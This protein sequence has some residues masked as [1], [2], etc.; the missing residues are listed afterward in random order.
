MAHG[1]GCWAS[2]IFLI[3]FSD[4]LSAQ[5]RY[6]IVE[7][8]KHGAFVGNIAED[9]GLKVQ[10]LRTRKCRLLSDNNKQYLAM[11][12]DNGILFVNERIDRE[13]LCGQSSVCSIAFE[14]RVEYPL[15]MFGFEVEVLDLN[16]NSP[17]FPQSSFSIQV[18]ESIVPGARFPLERAQDP[19]V[20]TNTVST[21]Q[22]SSNE[23]FGL[24]M[25]T[26]RDGKKVAELFLEKPLDRERRSVFQLVLTAFDG[27]SPA[28]SGT[29]QIVINV[30]DINDN[31]PKFDRE[32][33]RVSM[34]EN[35][36]R[37]TFVTK[38]QAKDL[39]EGANAEIR[40]SFSE[41]AA[42]EEQELFTLDPKT[43]D[44]RVQGILDYEKSNVFELDVQA[45]DNGAFAM[46][47]RSKVVV[48]LID[49]NDNAPEIRLTSV[50]STVREDAVPGTVIAAIS[51]ADRDSG[52]NGEVQC[53]IP[54][55][56]PIK[57]QKSPTNQYK[58]VTNNMLDREKV[59]FYNVSITAWDSGSPPLSTNK[60][61]LVS[62]S[63]IND[64]APR[65][66][67][68]SYTAY[69]MENNAP[70]DSILSVT[71]LDP[72]LD[73]NSHVS[74][75][76]LEN[77]IQGMTSFPYVSIDSKSGNIYA[78]RSF[79]YERLK[80][81]QIQVQA[82]DSGSPSLSSSAAVNVIILDQNDNAPAVV[83]PVT[84]NGSAT[85]GPVPQSAPAGYLV[86]KV[87]A[88]DADSGQNA[89]LSYQ[90]RKATDPSLISVGLKTGEIKLIRSVSSHDATTQDLLIS[91]N[92]NGQPTLSATV[93][94]AF[95]IVANVTEKYFER[96][97]VL[98]N[99][100]NFSDL[101]LYLII[102]LGSTSFIFLLTIMVLIAIKCH[103]DSDNGD[104]CSF[105][106]CRMRDS[107]NSFMRRSAPKECLNYT[108][109]RDSVP[110]PGSYNYRFSV[111][112]DSS[113]TDFLFLK[114]Y[115]PTL[116]H[117]TLKMSDNN[118][119]KERG[120][121]DNGY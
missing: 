21:Y 76:I 92:D 68:S 73:Q 121:E 82:R 16:D 120:Q 119:A 50:S 114:T 86:T 15:E 29:A 53:Q 9:L 64:N 5:I 42:Q 93:T 38:V 58:L 18:A 65:F 79:D 117:S 99:A 115:A 95:S 56:L 97:N 45:V 113:K 8:L 44:I 100:N 102:T 48:T 39:D 107:G 11:N 70:G 85:V 72:D 54:Q 49:V 12:L 43:G 30:L 41:H 20:G 40:Y 4:L 19:D 104:D 78:L 61:I 71:A 35:A 27:G 57:L 3:I 116:P 26:R 77:P 83:S 94:I 28:L 106:C 25:Q 14:V 118:M 1:L 81:F 84:R 75:S 32:E 2:F 69:V 105:C 63:D 87:M 103:Q 109:V 22:I 51:V 98:E 33:Y 7:E 59:E 23:N 101:N 67:Q 110:I 90:L 47:G 96:S 34:V 46:T 10:K 66:D 112:P 74:Y 24:K 91:V 13:Q 62:V 37:G 88:T 36:P 6:S 52:K 55:H 108:G 111:S 80:H 31:V 89:R 17:R 60:T